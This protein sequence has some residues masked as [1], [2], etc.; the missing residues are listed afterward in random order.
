MI[1]GTEA[2]RAK[3]SNVMST[4]RFRPGAIVEFVPARRHG[5]VGAFSV[6]RELPDGAG[7]PHYRIQS[8]A[9]G[10]ERV[11]AE[12]ELALAQRMGGTPRG[13]KGR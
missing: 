3:R 11:A 5:G 13:E 4:S 10:R 12:H 2:V 1:I 9:D 6:V 7:E 8:V